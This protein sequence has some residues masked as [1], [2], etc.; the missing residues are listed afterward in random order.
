[1][2]CTIKNH[3]KM[4]QSNRKNGCKV[5]EGICVKFTIVMQNLYSD[6]SNVKL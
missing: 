2:V 5:N 3:C 4:V 6:Q 1:M